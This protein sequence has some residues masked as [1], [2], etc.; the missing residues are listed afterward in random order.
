M[1]QKGFITS[2]LLYGILSLFLVLILGTIS[3]IANR[4]L[5]NDKIKQSALDDVQNLTTDESC[6][7]VENDTIVGY[8]DEENL[9][10]KTVFIP[11]TIN[12][13]AI[14]KIGSEAFSNKNLKNVTINSNIEVI[15]DNAFEGNNNM[16]FIFKNNNIEIDENHWG[17]QDAS[18]R[19]D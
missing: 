5:A 6:F 18:V 8:N 4:K 16:L 12:N 14:K 15:E 2:A 1:K 13:I 11:K 17:A 10:T 7:I 19:I 3:I 9:C